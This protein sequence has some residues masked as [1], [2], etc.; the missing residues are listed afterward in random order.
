[1]LQP[2]GPGSSGVDFVRANYPTLQPALRDRFDVFGFDVRGVGRSSPMRC[3]DDQQYTQEYSKAK[4][5]PGKGA[6]GFALASAARFNA[7]CQQKIA[8]LTPFVGTAF[9]A[10]DIDLLRQ[11]L[12]ENRLTFYGRSFGTYIGTVYASMF[13][14]HVRAMALDGAYDP[15]RYANSPYTYDLPQYVA[16]DAAMRRFL[17]WCAD[18]PKM[19]SFGNG[20]PTAAFDKLIRSL[21]QQ[22][23][24]IPGKGAANG[25]TLAYRLVFNLN[26]GKAFWPTLG[27]ALQQAEAR[28]A[29][30][31]LLLPP[32]T[33][34]FD[35]LTANV[36]V[37]CADRK[38]PRNPSQL[39]RNTATTT[40]LAPL[41]GPPVA[42]A[43]PFY[44]QNH[45]TACVQWPAEQVSRYNGSYR[46]AGTPKILV[47]GTTGDPDTPY[48]D[49][50]TLS[51]TFDNATLLTF[52]G[53]GHAAFGRSKCATTAISSYLGDLV[54][55]Q[56]G[57]VCDDEA[58]PHSP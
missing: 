4:G 5:R 46:A 57:T 29:T 56:P 33:A 2:G 18:T 6:F 11:A 38:Y 52:K 14:A 24:T 13:P 31:I 34:S 17:S 21:D 15:V 51:K 47:V 16:L 58:P 42:Y 20:R 55:P 54:V 43:P 45:A 32:S 1:M 8:D 30:S 26:A 37:E 35:F 49:A 36:V 19:C 12:G 10:R 3:W 44:D 39:E 53:E 27:K 23:V 7:A 41:L 50:V 22:P 40:R 25:F 9:V 48:Q 28:D